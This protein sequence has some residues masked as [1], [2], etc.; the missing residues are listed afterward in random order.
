MNVKN[1]SIQKAKNGNLAENNLSSIFRDTNVIVS[2]N[3]IL[4]C[5]IV[6]S[7]DSTKYSYHYPARQWSLYSDLFKISLNLVHE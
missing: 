4:D 7:L 6:Y 3:W 2:H 1:T 5:T